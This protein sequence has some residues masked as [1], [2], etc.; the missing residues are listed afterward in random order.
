MFRLG[1][2]SSISLITAL[3]AGLL[4]A[5]ATAAPTP[6]TQT[7]PSDKIRPELRSKF[8][9]RSAA[10]VPMW[11]R[12]GD[13]ADL[14]KASR[15]DDWTQRG[16]AVA[17]ALQR[18]AETA[19]RDVRRTLDAAG[20]EYK[21]FWATNAVY[22]RNGSLALAEQLAADTEVQGLHPTVQ[23]AEPVIDDR[24]AARAAA[25]VEW[26]VAAIRADQVWSQYGA[27]GASITVANIDTGVQYDHP[28]LAAQYRGRN[29]DGTV[30]HDY[31]W[32][33][34]AGICGGTPCDL[35][36]HGTHTMGT[37]AGDDGAGN[38]VG[39]APQVRWIAA[40]G[41]C[42]DDTALIESGQWMLLP[43]DSAGQ[44]PDASKRPHIINNSWGSGQPGDDPFMSDITRA[45]T[46]SGIFGVWSNGNLGPGCDTASAPG[47]RIDNYS[48]GAYDA[49]GTIADF[50]SRGTGQNGE[51]KPNLSA[52]GVDVRS[53]LPG[54]RFGVGS[55]TSMAAPHVA[56][57]IALLWSAAP[58]LVGDVDSTRDAAGRLGDRRT[59]RQ[60]R[61]HSGPERGR[62]QRVRRGPA[63][64]AP[65]GRLG[66]GRCDRD[67]GCSPSAT[68]APAT[69]SAAPN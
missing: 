3:L 60:L 6:V 50:S 14:T 33:D 48:V 69:R 32:F 53:S 56:G 28:A 10:G 1:R 39:V 16:A 47:S 23:Y 57:A 18:A 49:N 29:A 38:Q 4:A 36:G 62:Q 5:P 21:A 35:N 61:Q 25:T 58:G 2:I 65:A 27:R 31:N 42:P 68:G 51:T 54:N 34:A 30:D 63:G 46:A 40:N 45:W 8:T 24:D 64:R 9:A 37:M 22:V 52:P 44:H 12:F 67:G 41:C 59:G 17:A 19:Q 20:T 66:A 13:T 43:T 11:V 55:G 26:G 7:A 15:T